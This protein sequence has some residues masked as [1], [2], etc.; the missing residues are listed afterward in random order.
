[1]ESVLS[2]VVWR[3]LGWLPPFLLKRIFSP[4]WLKNNIYIDIRPRNTSVEI[5]QPDNPSIRIFLEL[6]NNTHFDIVIDRLILKFIYGA[7]MCVFRCNPTTDSAVNWSTYSALN[8]T[9]FP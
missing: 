6:R 8:W 2:S 7:E 3:F 4:E 9:T 5:Q 1:M